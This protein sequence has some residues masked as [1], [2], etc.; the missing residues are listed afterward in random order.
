MRNKK[1]ESFVFELVIFI[2]LNIVFSSLLIVF[3][4]RSGNGTLIYEQSY[5]KQI[6]LLIDQAKP[7]MTLFVDMT[8][9]NEVAE[10]NKKND[11]LVKIDNEKGEILVSL[12]SKG[13]YSYSYFTD[14]DIEYRISGNYLVVN[15]REKAK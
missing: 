12:S 7:E 4:V 5:A 1:G 2:I 10:K 8:K 15:V 14:Y 11:E 6:G 3:A 13:G 9:A